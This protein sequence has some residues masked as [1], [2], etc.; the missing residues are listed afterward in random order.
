MVR[1]KVLQPVA[2]LR[3]VLEVFLTLVVVAAVGWLRPRWSSLWVAVIPGGVVFAWLLLHED[4][5][6]D[7]VGLVDIAWYVAMSLVV[8]ALFAVTCGLG[9]IARQALM[10]RTRR[11]P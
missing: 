6:F 11:S 1:V 7:P 4:V 10:R 9:I 8:G 5:P 2:T 3:L